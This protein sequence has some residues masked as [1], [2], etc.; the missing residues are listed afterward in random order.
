M[1][2]GSTSY[3]RKLTLTGIFFILPVFLYF[4]VLYWYPLISAFIIS[5]QETIPGLELRFA[6]LKTYREVFTDE[7]FWNSLVNTLLFALQAVAF[8]VILALAISIA[9]HSVHSAGFRNVLT[10]FYVLPTL[11]SLAAA[12][13]IWEWLFHPRFGLTNQ[14]FGLFGLPS[15]KFLQDENQV[16]SSLAVINVW[17]RVGFAVLILLAG[18]QSIPETYFDAAKVDGAKGLKLYWFI[19]LPLLL[20]HLGA[21]VLLEVIF[22]VKIFDIVYVTTQGGPAGSSEMLMLYL[23]NNA[24]RFYRIDKAAVTAVFIF[25]VLLAFGIL[26]RRL[27]AGRRYEL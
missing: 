20:P 6:G 16:I 26:Q 22:A 4:I 18:L 3:I 5:F 15:L 14:L 19:T 1:K 24:F 9:L 21:V 2:L 11:V 12:G 8:N 23:Y 7:N 13:F 10:L 25:L 27:L 17:V